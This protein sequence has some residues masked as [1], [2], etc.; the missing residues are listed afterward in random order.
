MAEAALDRTESPDD[1][2]AARRPRSGA[3]AVRTLRNELAMTL[4]RAQESVSKLDLASRDEV[5]E[6]R[7]NLA[8]TV[9]RAHELL[10]ELGHSIEVEKLLAES[11]ARLQAQ[12]WRLGDED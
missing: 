11:K 5:S 6:L 10:S 1:A 4:N 3:R 7:E 2:A 8:R 9:G 12:S